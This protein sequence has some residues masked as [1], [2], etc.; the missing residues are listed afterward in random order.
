MVC[1]FNGEDL[2]TILEAH[3]AML[4]ESDNPG[5]EGRSYSNVINDAITTVQNGTGMS[6]R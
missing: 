6:K 3:L 2:Q 4:T 5:S 1:N